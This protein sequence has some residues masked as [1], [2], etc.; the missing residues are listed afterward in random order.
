MTHAR[1]TLPRLHDLDRLHERF[2]RQQGPHHPR[3]QKFKG[4]RDTIG[5][6]PRDG[7]GEGRHKGQQPLPWTYHY[8]DGAEN[9]RG[10]FQFERHMEKENML[11][12]LSTPEEY[13]GA[14]LFLLSDASSFTT[15]RCFSHLPLC[16]PRSLHSTTLFK[17]DIFWRASLV[18]LRSPRKCMADS[19]LTDGGFSRHR[20]WPYSLVMLYC[21]LSFPF[22]H[23]GGRVRFA[24]NP[25]LEFLVAGCPFNNK[26]ALSFFLCTLES[27]I[28]SLLS[29]FK[30]RSLSFRKSNSSSSTLTD[31]IWN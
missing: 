7:V 17:N 11:G 20:Q 26:H 10:R 30:Q 29:T 25:N 3:L 19:R 13:R 23:F 28:S 18:A 24:K 1:I 27:V 5:Q 21:R 22:F 14:A 8:A 31:L 12:R 9:P 15:G 2:R 4:G 16:A 6:K